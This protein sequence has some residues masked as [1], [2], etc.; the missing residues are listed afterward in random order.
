M[1]IAIT[2]ATGFIGGHLT[3]R[4]DAEG[5]A[6]VVLTRNPETARRT[7]PNAAD[8]VHWDPPAAGPPPGKLEGLDAVV[9]LAGLNLARRWTSAVKSEIFD[10]RVLSTRVLATTL[11]GLESPPGVLI[12][13]S[14]IGF[15]GPRDDTPLEED[16]PG[17]SDFLARLCQQWEK[18][19]A[20][21][22]HRGVRVVHPRVGIVL[23]RD[24]GALPLMLTPFRL[25]LGG[26]IGNGQQWMSWVHIDDVVGLIL[27]AIRQTPVIG[28]MNATA[29]T[30]VRNSDFS[31]ALGRALHRP[32]FLPTPV[33]G[34]KLLFG[35]FAHV[36]T[37][38]QRVVP[39][40]A[41]ASGYAFR[42][43]EL[44]GAL[45]DVVQAKP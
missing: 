39:A 24:G 15:Y 22:A 32:A 1:R 3:A 28:P 44:G 34:L 18:A 6:Y 42:Y 43:P 2:G 29:P 31:K 20:P 45:S 13:Q 25:G 9:H 37:T 30:P 10:S 11:A 26:P 36:L 41:S 27:H 8:I 16:A 7:R 21:A 14:A 12:S 35:E 17:G 38:G 5:T 33:F 19:A 23:G 4:L 40:K